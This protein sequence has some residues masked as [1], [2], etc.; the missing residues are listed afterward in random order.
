MKDYLDIANEY[1]A[2]HGDTTSK[3]LKQHFE[4]QGIK[5][6]LIKAKQLKERLTVMRTNQQLKPADYRISPFTCYS[7]WHG[8][9]EGKV[10]IDKPLNFEY[11]DSVQSEIINI[12]SQNYPIKPITVLEDREGILH[13]NSLSPVV[14]INF[15]ENCYNGHYSDIEESQLAWIERYPITLNIIS[16]SKDKD[17]NREL[18]YKY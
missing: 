9:S 11:T 15:L 2:E 8:C 5:I 4:N 18:F 16:P 1:V 13:V 14:I 17:I 3:I 10:I 12:I 6:S 7:L